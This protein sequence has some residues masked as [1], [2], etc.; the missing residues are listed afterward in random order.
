VT[1]PERSEGRSRPPCRRRQLS[2]AD[3]RGAH[4]LGANLSNVV[5][6]DTADFA[7][8]YFDADTQLDSAI[9]DSVM[10]YVVGTCPSDPHEH[11]IDTDR[12]GHGDSCNG[13]NELAEPGSV[14]LLAGSALR[15]VLARRSG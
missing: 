1:A 14:A 10:Y 4:L 8:A 15:A 6:G 3:V 5:N 2:N 11:W 13:V 12:D 9:D 7:G